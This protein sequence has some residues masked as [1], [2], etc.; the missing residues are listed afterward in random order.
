MPGCLPDVDLSLNN[1]CCQRILYSADLA[2]KILSFHGINNQSSLLGSWRRD[3]L[4][5]LLNVWKEK[6]HYTCVVT[7]LWEY[8]YVPNPSS[9]SRM[10]HKINFLTEFKS[11][12]YQ[13]ISIWRFTFRTATVATYSMILR[14]RL[15]SLTEE[16]RF[17][18]AEDF[19]DCAA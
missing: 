11:Q 18:I 12:L 10:R 3:V 1:R 16:K 6:R 15:S 17:C 13:R 14:I 4:I 5:T 2:R 7:Q 19:W 9:T 8:M